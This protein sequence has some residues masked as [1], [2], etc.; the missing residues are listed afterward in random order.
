[1]DGPLA[2][3]GGDLDDLGTTVGLADLPDLAA[4]TARTRRIVVPV[5]GVRGGRLSAHDGDADVETDG[6]SFDL[7]ITI[8]RVALLPSSDGVGPDLEPLGGSDAVRGLVE[9]VDRHDDRVSAAGRVKADRETARQ[10][11]PV[12]TGLDGSRSLV[13]DGGVVS[14]ETSGGLAKSRR[15]Q[16]RHG[17]SVCFELGGEFGKRER[18][19]IWF[20]WQIRW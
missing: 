5:D 16:T 17:A 12:V 1:M 8:D 10:F 4:V 7:A 9:K 19:V 6:G 15:N 18:K 13:Q 14:D 3:A 20:W 11:D 2:A